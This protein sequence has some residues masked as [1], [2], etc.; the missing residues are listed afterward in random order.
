MARNEATHLAQTGGRVSSCQSLSKPLRRFPM[1]CHLGTAAALLGIALQAA[2]A[3]VGHHAVDDAIILKAGECQMEF[4]TDRE[5]G[6]GRTLAHVGPACRVGAG[7]L[8]VNL[9]RT[10]LNNIP[11]GSD[12]ATVWGPQLEWAAP[13]SESL[14]VGVVVGALFRAPGR[15][16]SAV[17]CWC[18]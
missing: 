7:E 18:L 11:H 6:G 2:H 8:G 12:R 3:A 1:P 9:D 10:H 14:S 16:G 13:L 5:R 15:D 4:W 17:R